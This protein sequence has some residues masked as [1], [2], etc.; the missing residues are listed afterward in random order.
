MTSPLTAGVSRTETELLIDKILTILEIYENE[1]FERRGKQVIPRAV[2]LN[3][4]EFLE[5]TKR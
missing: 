4:R 1:L 2:I 5:Q 3:E